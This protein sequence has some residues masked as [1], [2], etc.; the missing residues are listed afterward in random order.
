MSN[1]TTSTR[2]PTKRDRFNALLAIPAVAADE[3]LVEFIK[4]EIE[5][6]DR[7]NAA[8]PKLTKAQVAAASLREVIV[9]E[10]EPSVAYTVS[11]AMKS[12]PSLVSD[13]DMSNQRASRLLNDL[14]K[15]GKVSKTTDK[16]KSYF[17]V[18][19]G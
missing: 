8:E 18:V 1:T 7:K 16:R 14:V 10:M 5:L 3:A 17:T 6:L 15:E 19:E 4:H 12:L 11:E 13:P 2:K 9:S